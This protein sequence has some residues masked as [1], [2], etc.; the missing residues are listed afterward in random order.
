MSIQSIAKQKQNFR[1]KPISHTC[2]NCKELSQCFYYYDNTGE[3][4]EGKCPDT[5]EHARPTYSDNYRCGIGG[6]AVKR[7]STCDNLIL[8]EVKEIEKERGVVL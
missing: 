7:L 8:K 1:D 2:N 3:R 4:I 5:G 6:F